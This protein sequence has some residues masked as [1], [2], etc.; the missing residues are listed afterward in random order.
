MTSHSTLEYFGIQRNWLQGDQFAVAA[1]QTQTPLSPPRTCP[2]NPWHLFSLHHCIYVYYPPVLYIN[3]LTAQYRVLPIECS[4]SKCD[5]RDFSLK[6]F[7]KHL[8][9]TKEVDS[10]FSLSSFDQN[11]M[12]SFRMEYHE[13]SYFIMQNVTLSSKI[14]CQNMQEN[15]NLSN[16][17]YSSM[18]CHSAECNVIIYNGMSLYRMAF[19]HAEWNFIV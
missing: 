18:E 14:E 1:K 19:Y 10:L 6:G 7:L 9:K 16:E 15:F 5:R 12:L 13:E 8:Q 3:C 11:R 17:T 2:W 4:T